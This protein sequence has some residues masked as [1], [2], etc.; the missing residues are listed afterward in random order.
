MISDM[1]PDALVGGA[2]DSK[3]GA[4]SFGKGTENPMYLRRSVYKGQLGLLLVCELGVMN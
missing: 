3:C 1:M 4:R 2:S